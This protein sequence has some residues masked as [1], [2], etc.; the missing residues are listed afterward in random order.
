MAKTRQVG[1]WLNRVDRSDSLEG[2][3]GD[4]N[5]EGDQ[6]WFLCVCARQAMRSVS[7]TP[8]VGKRG[9]GGGGA[10]TGKE[11]DE[12]EAGAPLGKWSSNRKERER[13]FSIPLLSSAT[14]PGLVGKSLPRFVGEKGCTG[15]IGGGAGEG[16]YEVEAVGRRSQTGDGY[17]P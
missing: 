11:G 6:V 5:R 15:F 12:S 13:R 7:S 10:K 17:Q 4:Q 1:T 3:S 16:L 14:R 8:Q 2:P 9:D